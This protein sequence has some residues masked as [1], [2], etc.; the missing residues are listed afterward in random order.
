VNCQGRWERVPTR[1]RGNQGDSSHELIEE[2][3]GE[4][5]LSVGRA[6][7]HPLVDE[8]R[9]DRTETVNPESKRLSD[10]ACPIRPGT[11]VGHATQET[12][13]P[14][15]PS[16]GMSRFSRSLILEGLL[17]PHEQP[18]RFFV[19]PGLPI[20]HDEHGGT[21]LRGDVP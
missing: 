15:T 1:R 21:C 3:D 4:D 17:Q 8:I 13:F 16:P 18:A 6:V 5:H 12:L 20:G 14:Q 11:Q 10:I 9:T 7:D 19:K 2:Q